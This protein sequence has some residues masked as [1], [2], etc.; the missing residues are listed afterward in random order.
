MDN[1][2]KL[3][4][5]YLKNHLEKEY[6]VSPETRVNAL[7]RIEKLMKAN[8]P[9]IVKQPKFLKQIPKDKFLLELK[10]KKGAELNG[11]EISVIN[12]FYKFL[13]EL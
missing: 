11:A 7:N 3:K 8:F 12:G 13:P 10:L 2:K 6:L 5:L 1:W 4:Q 9:D